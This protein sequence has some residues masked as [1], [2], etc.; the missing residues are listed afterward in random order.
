MQFTVNTVNEARQKL[1]HFVGLFDSDPTRISVTGNFR[2]GRGNILG[3]PR[4]FPVEVVAMRNTW[5]T[6]KEPN[7]A[8]HD[9]KPV[10]PFEI[11]FH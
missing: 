2:N 8:T 10:G 5:M 1:T 7:G 3:A 11:V 9:V 6:I 4:H